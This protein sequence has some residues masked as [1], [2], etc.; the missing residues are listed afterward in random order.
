M[1]N[2]TYLNKSG[3]YRII[4]VINNKFYIGSAINLR[5]RRNTHF[6]QLNNN[7]HHS[8]YLQRSYNKYGS[9]NFKFEVLEFVDKNELIEKEQYFID[10]LKPNYN[11]S[12]VAGSTRGIKFSEETKKKMSISKTGI[13]FS[14]E[15]KQ[16]ISKALKGHKISEETK[17]KIS[18]AHLGK[19]KERNRYR[20][21]F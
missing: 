19:K 12:K 3:I 15:R 16:N 4:N 9:N 14:K 8:I 18:R 17:L 2:R 20:K 1:T 6:E 5:K 10:T 21:S 13:K 7:K 11:C